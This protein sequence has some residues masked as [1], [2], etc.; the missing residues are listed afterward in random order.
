MEVWRVFARKMEGED[1]YERAYIARYFIEVLP[2]MYNTSYKRNRCIR[3]ISKAIKAEEDEM[4][5]QL[6]RVFWSYPEDWRNAIFEDLKESEPDFYERL[7]E[8][9]F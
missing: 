8:P 1:I 7:K 6:L 5:K 2:Q 3:A 9:P 4:K